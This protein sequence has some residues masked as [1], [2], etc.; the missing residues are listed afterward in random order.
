M[1]EKNSQQEERNPINLVAE[2]F[3]LH[4]ISSGER[5]IKETTEIV[6]SSEKNLEEENL[7]EEKAEEISSADKIDK[8]LEPK[9]PPL[10]MVNRA[11]IQMQSPNRVFFYWS[12]KSDPFSILQKIFGKGSSDYTLVAKLINQTENS[13]YIF[14]IDK[15]GSTWLNVE[16][17]STYQ[18]EI[19][20]FAKN[21]PFIRLL[22]SNTIQTPRSAPSPYFDWSPEFAISARDFA[23]V[24]D[25]TGFKQDAIEMALAG[26]DKATVATQNTFFALFGQN[27]PNTKPS[28]LRYALFA[29]ASG[30]TLEDLRHHISPKLFA[31]LERLITEMS[32]KLTT[33]KIRAAVH[34]NFGLD[35]EIEEPDEE[36]F[37]TFGASLIHFRKIPKK[38]KFQ[39]P[40][41][42]PVSSK[43]AADKL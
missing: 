26:D 29:L 30:L 27:F 19:G 10:P 35:E 12:L 17:D 14:P 11:Q 25:A 38:R 36:I 24:L 20:L 4:P 22:F 43:T 1:T 2:D 41:I 21:R 16:S 33:E 28:E 13:E 5:L 18:V 23:E 3:K 42:S 9:L 32:E 34:E 39:F 40:K 7:I 31:L 6:F 15:A 37:R 8:L